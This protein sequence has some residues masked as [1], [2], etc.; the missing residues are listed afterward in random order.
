MTAVWNQEVDVR[1]LYVN[2]M[3]TAKGAT[4]PVVLFKQDYPKDSKTY[5]EGEEM[6]EVI[7]WLVP[8]FAPLGHYYVTV[9]IHGEKVDDK[10][11]C[12]IGQ[13]DINK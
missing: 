11:L 5:E 8:A 10:H 2:V 9:S 7:E 6:N 12:Q 4:T 13:F 3:F 1:G